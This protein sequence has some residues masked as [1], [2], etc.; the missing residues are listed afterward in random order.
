MYNRKHARGQDN[1]DNLSPVLDWPADI[2]AEYHAQVKSL[3]DTQR[4]DL[5][6]AEAMALSHIRTKYPHL[7]DQHEKRKF[8][9]QLDESKKILLNVPTNEFNKELHKH[10][11]KLFKKTHGWH[12]DPMKVFDALKPIATD[13]FGMEEQ[14]ADELF[15]YTWNLAKKNPAKPLSKGNPITVYD[16]Y[17]KGLVGDLALA[18]SFIKA[19]GD[20]IR[21]VAAN[22]NWFI[23]DDGVW[24]QDDVL[25]H[26]YLA[27]QACLQ[28]SDSEIDPYKKNALVRWR[29]V[30][31]MLQASRSD[32][33]I[34]AEMSQW[35][36][37][38]WLVAADSKITDLHTGVERDA[39]PDDYITKQLMITPKAG[40]VPQRW[41]TF[42][43]Q[44]TGENQELIDYLQLLCGYCL[45]G[46]TREQQFFF[47]YGTGKNGKSVFMNVIYMLLQDYTRYIP[48]TLLMAQK[49]EGHK[50]TLARLQGA[51]I[52]MANEVKQGSRWNEARLKDITGGTPI[53]ANYMH[54][55]TFEFVPQFKLIIAGNHKP[56]LN[57]L[58]EAIQR[59]LRLIPFTVTIPES[60]R[61]ANLDHILVAEEGAAILAWMIEGC[62]KWQSLKGGLDAALPTVVRVATKD[63][64]DGEDKVQQFLSENFDVDP[65]SH[66]LTE[67]VYFIYCQWAN[68]E[69]IHPNFQWPKK[70]LINRLKEKG[71]QEKHTKRGNAIIG[72]KKQD[73]WTSDEM[74]D[75]T[76]NSSV[77]FVPF[78]G[79]V[80]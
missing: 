52:V 44:V 57:E 63:Y 53:T 15:T 76:I 64:F 3:L 43:W 19:Y 56:A 78:R 25:D 17:G 70:V 69:G 62:L 7:D 11:V 21:Y 33:R 12:I 30:Q 20:Q 38:S 66:V 23:Y 18:E 58:G 77:P 1:S 41:L 32:H 28:L 29:I 22:R 68:E 8:Q 14:E 55:N 67:N 39:R 61:I 40:T 74:Q 47:F 50:E 13:Q 45:T 71:L 34:K 51:R 42:L 73:D 27:W 46:S 75:V 24:E 80:Q 37:D 36:N 31:T 54:Q 16:E 72:L 49:Y 5:E 10:L 2:Q 65:N 26:E 79:V 9:Y 48:D 4:V 6:V 60:H 35:D 59:R